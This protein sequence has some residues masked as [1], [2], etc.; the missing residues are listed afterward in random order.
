M[1]RVSDVLAALC[2]AIFRRESSARIRI[3]M[4]RADTPR[5]GFP[6]QVMAT[7]ESYMNKLHAIF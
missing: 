6:L 7:N 4:L 5:T 3:S 1:E 2:I